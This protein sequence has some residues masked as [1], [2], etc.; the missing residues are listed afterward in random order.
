MSSGVE[1]MYWV[2]WSLLVGGMGVGYGV[3]ERD[4]CEGEGMSDG[5]GVCIRIV[6]VS[7]TEW[8]RRYAAS[9]GDA[10]LCDLCT[11]RIMIVVEFK[12]GAVADIMLCAWLGVVSV[13]RASFKI[14]AIFAVRM[15]VIVLMDVGV[16][17]M[18][19]WAVRVFEVGRMVD[20]AEGWA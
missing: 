17:W 10:Y 4:V 20:E 12:G 11:D 13:A 14:M 1:M 6:L 2:L 5:D 8:G 15:R 9:A 3:G 18:E 16:D 7:R 19:W